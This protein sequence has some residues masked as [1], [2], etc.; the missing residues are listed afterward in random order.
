MFGVSFSLDS[1][2]FEIILACLPVDCDEIVIRLPGG[3]QITHRL[4]GAGGPPLALED[5]PGLVSDFVDYLEVSEGRVEN[6]L[7]G[8][9]NRLGQ[10]LAWLAARPD[11]DP[12][13]PETWTAYYAGLKK[14]LA[15]HTAKG[16][17]HIL[18]RFADWLLAAGR[19]RRHPL[20]G[21]EPPDLPTEVLPKA[22][23]RDH[24]KAMLA[25]AE[26]PRDQA[27]LLFFRDTG[28]RAAEALSLTWADLALDEG[29]VRVLGK[30]NKERWLFLRP[31]T[32][33][34]LAIYRQ[35]YQHNKTGPL[36]AGKKGPLTYDGLYKTF[37]R[38]AESVGLGDEIFNP[39]SFRH[40]FGRD[41]TIAG[42][43]TATLQD[44][45]GHGSME[46]TRIYT[47][48]NDTE[49]RDAHARYSPVEGDLD[50]LPLRHFW[51][52]DEEDSAPS[53][54]DSGEK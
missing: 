13:A 44:L 15:A 2:R 50:V 53:R 28:C 30:G 11:L 45:M 52:V 6:T 12:A 42:I 17:F 54:V 18:K 39:H 51:V 47:R 7:K 22:I 5:L 36:W 14:S 29:R 19:L 37:K 25:A 9:R 24:I 8:Y 40:A 35:S 27:L 48:F 20:A 1:G 16:H 10:F 3:A 41:T 43:P 32:R 49:L 26:S 23:F 38:L 4:A 31:I 34:A 46:V 21:V 33:Q